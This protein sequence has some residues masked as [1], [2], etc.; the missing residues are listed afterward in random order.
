M[1]HF[2]SFSFIVA[3]IAAFIASGSERTEFASHSEDLV[4]TEMVCLDLPGEQTEYTITLSCPKCNSLMKA[5]FKKGYTSTTSA[6]CSKC[7]RHYS[8]SYNWPGDHSEPTI[9]NIKEMR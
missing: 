2:I 6:K 5:N 1:N 7:S 8:I 9:T 3:V 4:I